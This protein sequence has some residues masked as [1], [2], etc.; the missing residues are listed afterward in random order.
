M[1]SRPS[2]QAN[3][4]SQAALAVASTPGS[5]PI[6]AMR[7]RKYALQ[8]QAQPQPTTS[9]SSSQTL[10]TDTAVPGRRGLRRNRSNEPSRSPVRP[11]PTGA[12][13]TTRTRPVPQRIG[14]YG[15]QQSEPAGGLGEPPTR[16]LRTAPSASDLRAASKRT[17][18]RPPVA[19]P[20]THHQQQ[21]QQHSGAVP[22]SAQG[23]AASRRLL[24]R[25]GSIQGGRPASL[26][27]RSGVPVGGSLG[28]TVRLTSPSTKRPTPRMP[29]PSP[30]TLG[31]GGGGSSESASSSVRMSQ[32]PS[33]Q[34]HVD[35]SA[36]NAPSQQ[37]VSD[38]WELRRRLREEEGT[39]AELKK[40]LQTK[41]VEIGDL[42]TA[43]RYSR[44]ESDDVQQRMVAAE[45]ELGETR[46]ANQAL[47][48]EVAALRA[49]IKA[50]ADVKSSG[51]RARRHSELRD[52][53]E[54]DDAAGDGNWRDTYAR[55]VERVGAMRDTY[56]VSGASPG[57]T[58]RDRRAVDGYLARASARNEHAQS[59][60]RQRRLAEE[61]AR[62]SRRQSTM[63]FAGLIRPSDTGVCGR[64]EQLHESLRTV[65]LDNDYYRE[66]NQKLRNSVTDMASRHNAMVRAFECERTRRREH[67]AR[68]LTEA[69]HMAARNRAIVEASQR[70]ELGMDSDGDE[71]ARRFGQAVRIA[72][73]APMPV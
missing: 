63:F 49:A 32:I 52:S 14:V 19:T 71:L 36:P 11:E 59:A 51:A 28:R 70:V 35:H 47:S 69:S 22:M 41:Q 54:N 27:A 13:S 50:Q 31:G 12:A 33:R 5:R 23:S 1:H 72:S 3:A 62:A 37:L 6:A 15:K 44:S 43:L 38:Y 64:C 21:Q 7:A 57:G 56:A 30:R 73:P 16:R 26:A 58:D 10:R 2:P 42:N 24:G 40:E 55:M 29:L 17:S 60:P 61:E 53:G 9:S 66:A 67:R 68:E 25:T 65:E 18:A 45:E 48:E 39:S 34:M 20:P 46:A 8:A 4:H